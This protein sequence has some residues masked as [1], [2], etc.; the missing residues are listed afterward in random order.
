LPIELTTAE[1]VLLARKRLGED[2]TDFADRFK[3]KWLAINRWEKGEVDPKPEHLR[4][5]RQLFREVLHDEED[6][7][8]L[9]F[10]EPID[11]DLRIGPQAVQIAVEIR[12]RTG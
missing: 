12:R 3:V 11:V 9:P 4:Q 10:D 2:Q 1:K 5:L 6:Q 7:L 8:V